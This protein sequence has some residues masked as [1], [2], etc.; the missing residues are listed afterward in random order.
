MLRL[1][2]IA[3]T[4][5]PE[6]QDRKAVLPSRQA[7]LDL[8]GRRREIRISPGRAALVSFGKTLYSSLVCS[9][10]LPLSANSIQSSCHISQNGT[11]VDFNTETESIEKDEKGLAPQA[12]ADQSGGDCGA[13][14]M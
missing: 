2:R 9:F 11:G 14:C 13:R 6:I 10:H 12:A 4:R 5:Q 7:C 1:P 3:H 8:P